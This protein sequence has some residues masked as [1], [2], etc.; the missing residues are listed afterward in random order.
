MGREVLAVEIVAHVEAVDEGE[1]ECGERRRESESEYTVEQ[2]EQQ[3]RRNGQHRRQGYALLL[4]H[5][6]DEVALDRLH[7]D[8]DRD[9]PEDGGRP[10]EE[11]QQPRRDR[12]EE[13]TSE[14]QSIMRNSSAVFCLKKNNT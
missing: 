3:L 12:S 4:D 8:I 6:R 5:R 10:V 11:R 9:D 7:R 13:H 2:P 1:P 14:L